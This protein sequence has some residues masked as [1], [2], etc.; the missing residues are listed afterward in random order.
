MHRYWFNIWDYY[1]EKSREY[2]FIIYQP[3]VLEDNHRR[4]NLSYL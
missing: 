4:L 3:L 1:K 2:V